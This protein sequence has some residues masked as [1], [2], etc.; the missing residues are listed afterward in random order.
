M[1]LRWTWKQKLVVVVLV[2]SLLA[3]VVT[4]LVTLAL[5]SASKSDPT[6]QTLSLDNEEVCLTP[7]C[8]KTAAEVGPCSAALVS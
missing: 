8:V 5:P 1:F 7:D 2:G 3:V 6:L 4:L